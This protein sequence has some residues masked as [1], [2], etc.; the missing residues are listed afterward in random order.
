MWRCNK[1]PRRKFPVFGNSNTFRVFCDGRRTFCVFSGRGYS[2]RSTGGR[3]G[4]R[5]TRAKSCQSCK[6]CLKPQSIRQPSNSAEGI[7]KARR[8]ARSQQAA[9]LPGEG[10][11]Q[12]VRVAQREGRNSL[13]PS[14][15]VGGT[16]S[17]GERRRG[18]KTT[19]SYPWHHPIQKVRDSRIRAWPLSHFECN[20]SLRSTK[21][22]ECASSASLSPQE[23]RWPQVSFPRFPS[24]VH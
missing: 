18:N 21:S 13:R 20:P 24:S 1:D 17:Q 9:T 3:L 4:A 10:H 19:S 22:H 6:S 15:V 14:T 16:P 2:P 12:H 23:G 8:R 7:A 5:D 11:N